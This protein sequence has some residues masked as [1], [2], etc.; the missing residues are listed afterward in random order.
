MH[1]H[2]ALDVAIYDILILCYLLLGEKQSECD[3]GPFNGIWCI[4]P[5]PLDFFCDLR[6]VSAQ[7]EKEAERHC[8]N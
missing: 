2:E 1:E 5:A 7:M 8:N 4:D 6:H 3:L